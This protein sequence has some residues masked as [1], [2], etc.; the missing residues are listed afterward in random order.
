MR[1]IKFRAW[2][3]KDNKIVDCKEFC[4][5]PYYIRADGKV[6]N[7]DDSDKNK[8]SKINYLLLQFT[9]FLDRNGKEI[10]EGDLVK[11]CF[12][13]NCYE[14]VFVGNGWNIF[15]TETNRVLEIRDKNTG[16]LEQ[17]DEIDC[18]R[19]MVVGNIFEGIKK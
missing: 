4:F 18:D 5:S 1:K 3:K 11:T 16:A 9:G 13:Y 6:I 17:D 12:D 15:N 8:Y 10:Y 19:M 14:V 7:L 2:N